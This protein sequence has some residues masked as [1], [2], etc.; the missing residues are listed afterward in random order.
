MNE[1]GHTPF[2]GRH[3]GDYA[4]ATLLPNTAGEVSYLYRELEGDPIAWWQPVAWEATVETWLSLAEGNATCVDHL[5]GFIRPLT[6]ENQVRLGL[7]WVA[8]LVLPNPSR[9]ANHSFL[10]SSWLIEV[11][12]TAS[13]EGMLPNWQR[14][15]D[16]LV[17][18]GTSR[19]AP[20]SE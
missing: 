12:Q 2:E 16:A 13:D 9:I 10:V 17:V 3:Y 14:V 6:V 7:P 1:T 5:I 18:A 15:V 4:L 20:Y 11:R 8:T 19:L